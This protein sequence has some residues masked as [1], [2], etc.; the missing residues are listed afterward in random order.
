MP[1]SGQVARGARQVQR[2]AYGRGSVPSARAVFGRSMQC[3]AEET[4]ETFGDNRTLVEHVTPSGRAPPAVR[5]AMLSVDRGHFCPAA[6]YYDAPAPLTDWGAPL[7]QA[8]VSAPSA[9]ALALTKAAE[10]LRARRS[11]PGP[12]RA[13]DV[14]AGTCLFAAYLWR[15]LERDWGPTVVHA[16]EILPALADR[17][18]E[19]VRHAGLPPG[20]VDVHCSDG[21]LGWPEAAPFDFIHVGAAADAIPPALVAQL[22][23]GGRLILPLQAG[24]GSGVT[25]L[26]C[27]DRAADGTTVCHTGPEVSFVPLR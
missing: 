13:L 12:L 10:W 19:A 21:R 25:H 6:A 27:L 17:G 7:G 24:R 16:V 22:T 1:W 20:A 26:R 2:R 3:D 5:S 18:R 15:M 14:G 11:A 23:P 4:A 9:H 8:T